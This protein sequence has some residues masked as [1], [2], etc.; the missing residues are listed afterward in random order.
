MKIPFVLGIVD[1]GFILFPT[2][3]I[4]KHWDY[5]GKFYDASVPCPLS[6]KR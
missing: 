3:S 1:G 2:F 5:G 4:F 6:L